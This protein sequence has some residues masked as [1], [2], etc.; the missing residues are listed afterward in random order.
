M[1]WF[2]TDGVTHQETDKKNHLKNLQDIHYKNNV[3]VKNR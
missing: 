3:I 2:K 1:V